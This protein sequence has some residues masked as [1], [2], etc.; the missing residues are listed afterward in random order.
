MSGNERGLPKPYNEKEILAFPS[1]SRKPSSIELH[2]VSNALR[3][4]M[5]ERGLSPTSSLD[6]MKAAQEEYPE[7]LK[8]DTLSR[9][10]VIGRWLR[11]SSEAAVGLAILAGGGEIVHANR[12]LIQQSVDQYQAAKAQETQRQAAAA[13]VAEADYRR[14][15]E[16]N[17]V[18]GLNPTG[19]STTG[20]RAK[21]VSFNP[22]VHYV[23][24]TVVRSSGSAESPIIYDIA[25]GDHLIL[26]S[27]E[28]DIILDLLDGTMTP[29]IRIIKEY[30]DF[31]IHLG[32]KST[33]DWLLR[34]P[35]QPT[36]I[37]NRVIYFESQNARQ[38]PVTI[39]FVQTTSGI[40]FQIQE[41][42]SFTIAP[43]M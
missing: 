42:Q 2:A 33:E 24:R 3:F 30:K 12:Q 22:N 9:R 26:D 16:T 11:R 35:G 5:D 17:R 41:Y 10:K 19:F 13:Q 20:W 40:R 15:M 34:A 6:V 27:N 23:P 43:G 25:G 29:R 31:V 14:N 36:D 18:L 8:R 32:V 37:D 38:I 21:Y 4:L 28:T 7:A 1:V 39:N